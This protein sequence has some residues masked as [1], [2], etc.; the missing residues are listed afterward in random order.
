MARFSCCSAQKG[1]ACG[2]TGLEDRVDPSLI[3]ADPRKSIRDGALVPTL[4]NGYTVYSQ[5]TLE[6]MDTICRAHGFDV[7]TAWGELSEAQRNVV[8]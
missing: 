1:E 4:K 6:V 2:G 5:V 7:H 8:L 3:V